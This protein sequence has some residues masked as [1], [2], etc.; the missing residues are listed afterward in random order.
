MVEGFFFSGA[1]LNVLLGTASF[2]IT[3]VR[4]KD[5]D[6]EGLEMVESNYTAMHE[7]PDEKTGGNG[8]IKK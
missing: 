8:K 5:H 2:G 3:A 7:K 4:S 6:A 1:F